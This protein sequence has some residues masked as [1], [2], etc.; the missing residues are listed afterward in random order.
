MSTAPLTRGNS[1]ERAAA[2]R[3]SLEGLLRPAGLYFPNRSIERTAALRPGSN[4]LVNWLAGVGYAVIFGFSFLMTKGA[5]DLLD[6]LELMFLRFSVAALVMTA[7]WAL[8]VVGHCCDF[9][10]GESQSGG[11]VGPPEPE[12]GAGGELRDEV[13]QDVRLEAVAILAAEEKGARHEARRLEGLAVAR[14]GGFDDDGLG[15][16]LRR[17]AGIAG[18]SGAFQCLCEGVEYL[19]GAVSEDEAF[20][21]D[22]EGSGSRIAKFPIL[23]VGVVSRVALDFLPD[24]VEPLGGTEGVEVGARVDDAGRVESGSPDEGVDIPS[25]ESSGHDSLLQNSEYG[26]GAGQMAQAAETDGR[27]QGVARVAAELSAVGG[28][29]GQETRGDPADEAHAGSGQRSIPMA[30]RAPP[31][32]YG[33]ARYATVV[34][35]RMSG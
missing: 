19:V 4:Q 5:L 21:R 2:R 29:H 12:R 35:V 15:L 28:K 3:Y 18:E 34:P 20:G 10:H 25:V 8:G 24:A 32:G 11:I 1:P 7:L 9:L 30:Q 26:E 6:P 17:G 27:A 31:A 23:G 22:I 14:V 16:V 33:T 13:G